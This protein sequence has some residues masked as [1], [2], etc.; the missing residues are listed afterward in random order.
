MSDKSKAKKDWKTFKEESVRQDDEVLRDEEDLDALMDDDVQ[1][2]VG[3]EHPTY[4]DLEEKLTIAEQKVHENWEKA[5]RAMAELENVRRRADR[6]I[7]NAHKYSLERFVDGLL[8]VVD[9]LEQALQLADKEANAGMHEG[10]ELTMKLLLGVLSKHH[11]EQLDPTGDMFDPQQHE[12]MSMQEADGVKSNTI[13][14]VFQKG[15]KLSDRV[16][17]PARVIVAK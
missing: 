17:R 2:H 16:I 5:T 11:V 4:P 7:A 10:L 12:A 14:L 6:D 9:S 15:Y 8:P 1:E 3:L 13:L